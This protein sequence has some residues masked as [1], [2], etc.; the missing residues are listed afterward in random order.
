MKS[1]KITK[2]SSKKTKAKPKSKVLKG[3]GKGDRPEGAPTGPLLPAQI[4]WLQQNAQR[5]VQHLGQELV[6]HLYRGGD[7]KVW[8]KSRAAGPLDNNLEERIK[9]WFISGVT[10]TF[11]FSADDGRGAIKRLVIKRPGTEVK[12]LP[13]AY[14]PGYQYSTKIPE[15]SITRGQIKEL[16]KSELQSKLSISFTG[17]D[18]YN[19]ARVNVFYDNER[20]S[21]H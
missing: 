8:I 12:I 16:I 1:R 19:K 6:I 15:T 21:K 9:T 4:D 5:V 10:D 17:A 2:K 13:G 11:E 3:R 14:S 18:M 7:G 20:I